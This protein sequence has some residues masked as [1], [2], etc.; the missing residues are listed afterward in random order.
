MERGFSSR[1]S[2]D[3]RVDWQ[4][5]DPRIRRQARRLTALG[6]ALILGIALCDA[7]AGGNWSTLYVLPVLVFSRA[8]TLRPLWRTTLLMIVLA[9]VGLIVKNALLPHEPGATPFDYRF[10]NRTFS[11]ITL[12]AMSKAMEMW[13]HWS[14]EQADAELPE[15]FR[16]QERDIGLTMAVLLCMPMVVVIGVADFYLP[17]HINLAILY[18]IPLFICGWIGSRRLLWTMWAMLT[19]FA[20]GAFVL[21]SP[22][23]VP[24]QDY[25]LERNRAIAVAAMTTVALFLQYG[26]RRPYEDMSDP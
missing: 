6:Y 22:T 11:A 19:V 4:S 15:N 17:S 16:H 23:T 10:I 8:G 20:I 18:P 7:F 25:G 14:I 13:D 21:G 9:Y 2:D 24:N 12:F 26:M 5:L 3:A 1:R